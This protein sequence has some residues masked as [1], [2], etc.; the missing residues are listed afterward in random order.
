MP[1]GPAERTTAT[2]C[3]RSQTS[4]SSQP[5]SR[6]AVAACPSARPL[7]KRQE[8]QPGQHPAA[9][10]QPGQQREQQQQD[11]RKHERPSEQHRPKAPDDVVAADHDFRPPPPKG[12]H[13]DPRRGPASS[14]CRGCPGVGLTGEFPDQFVKQLGRRPVSVA[15]AAGRS[16]TARRNCCTTAARLVSVGR[17]STPRR[18]PPGRRSSRRGRRR[19]A[20]PGPGSPPYR[21]TRPKA[22]R[23]GGRRVRCS[24]TR[25]SAGPGCLRMRR[26][27]GLQALDQ[28]DRK[29]WLLQQLAHHA[30]QLSLG[31]EVPQQLR[32]AFGMVGA[33]P[34]SAANASLPP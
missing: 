11:Q 21:A 27:E 5:A 31:Q 7:S 24:S 6:H 8:Q 13:Q 23:G 19:R 30:G 20:D 3:R 12:H 29:G 10:G 2:R 25:S 32:D 26:G 16:S 33:E 14:L 22:G 1:R 15:L 4:D 34:T 28:G 9:P 18:G 17:R